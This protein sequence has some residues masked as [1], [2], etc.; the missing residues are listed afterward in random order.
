MEHVIDGVYM[1]ERESL[2]QQ[3]FS[4]GDRVLVNCNGHVNEPGTISL[5]YNGIWKDVQSTGTA[6]YWIV[7]DREGEMVA[8]D[9]RFRPG[10]TESYHLTRV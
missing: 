5:S 3:Q 4:L 2:G 6:C 8:S 10:G 9:P 1:A 7:F